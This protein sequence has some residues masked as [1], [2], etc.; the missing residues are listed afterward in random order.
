MA[1]R[2]LSRRF[3][4]N[5]GIQTPRRQGFSNQIGLILEPVAHLGGHFAKAKP[6]RAA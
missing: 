6:E 3:P 2:L 5:P 4:G 1:S